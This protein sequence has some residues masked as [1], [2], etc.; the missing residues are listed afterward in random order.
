MK[1]RKEIEIIENILDKLQKK[2]PNI[3]DVAYEEFTEFHKDLLDNSHIGQIF[4]GWF[5]ENFSLHD[6]KRM[7]NLCF[8][9]LELDLEEKTLLR[10][11]QSNITG[12]FEVLKSTKDTVF[13]KDLVTLNEYPVKI[14]ELDYLPKKRSILE[15]CLVKNLNGDYFFF[16]GS[17]RRKKNDN[18]KLRLLEYTRDLTINEMVELEMNTIKNLETEKEM[19][20]DYLFD[21]LEMDDEEIDEFLESDETKRREILKEIIEEIENDE[22]YSAS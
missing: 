15:A 7:P 6:G 10:N 8:E 5:F 2:F 16:G 18:I 3:L 19:L 14:I 12:I 13:L 22:N 11:I 21:V 1:A 9:I 17:Y 4:Y 20:L